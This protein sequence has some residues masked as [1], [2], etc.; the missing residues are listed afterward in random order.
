MCHR[1]NNY[2]NNTC[3]SSNMR[4]CGPWHRFVSTLRTQ[5]V[6]FDRCVPNDTIS[7]L[8]IKILFQNFWKNF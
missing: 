1:E 6:L 4:D 8:N 7:K 3:D 5:S 2:E